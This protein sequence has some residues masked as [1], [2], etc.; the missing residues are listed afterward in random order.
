MLTGLC[1]LLFSKITFAHFSI[2]QAQTRLVDEVYV[3]NAEFDYNFTGVVIDALQNG[4]SL[5]LRLNIRIE[6]E[7]AYWWNETITILKQSYDLKY[8]ALSRQYVLKYSNRQ[9]NFS[10]LNA[11][12]SRLNKLKNF[13]LVDKHSIENDQTYW[14]Y[15]QIYL[16]IESLPVP[17]RPIAYLSSQWRLSSDWYLCPLKKH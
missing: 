16:D 8:Y 14:V 5:S 2:Q 15:L 1:L 9:E 6:R 4:V 11:V 7:R 10:S 3:L 17:L 13:P 12:L